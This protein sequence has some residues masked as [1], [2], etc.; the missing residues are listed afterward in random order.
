MIPS[1]IKTGL[2][3]RLVLFLCLLGSIGV[4]AA[5]VNV[6]TEIQDSF[7]QWL[8]Q[9]PPQTSEYS[10]TITPSGSFA[11]A[12]SQLFYTPGVNLSERLKD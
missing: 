9:Q 4:G 12:G 5:P 8:D 11:S 6:G 7:H 2:I 1:I 3:R 10:L